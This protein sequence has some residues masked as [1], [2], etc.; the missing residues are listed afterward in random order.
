MS[1]SRR[2]FKDLL[3]DLSEAVN[4]AAELVSLGKE[5]W[6]SERPLRLAGE[7]VVGRIGDIATKLPEELVAGTTELPWAE[8]KGMRILVDQAYH[9]IDYER[10]WRTLR[11]DVPELERVVRRW[12]EQ[13]RAQGLGKG[14]VRER[15][16][17]H[18]LG[19]D[20]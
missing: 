17:G 18:D 14:A 13:E 2:G 4:A 16:Q 9:S 12:V 1:P 6:E 10:V 5:R 3:A 7:A 11:D 19:L 8:I 20:R 15:G